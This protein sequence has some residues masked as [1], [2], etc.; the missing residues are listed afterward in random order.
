[1]Y[2]KIVN[3]SIEYK[4]FFGFVLAYN[5]AKIAKQSKHGRKLELV[6]NFTIPVLSLNLFMKTKYQL[7]F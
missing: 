4:N 7:Y 3:L 1:M 2:D 5:R 6:Y